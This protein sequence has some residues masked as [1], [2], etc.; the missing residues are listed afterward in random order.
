MGEGG[1]VGSEKFC[2]WSTVM[3]GDLHARIMPVPVKSGVKGDVRRAGERP[4]DTAA[5]A[6]LFRKSLARL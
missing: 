3:L 2:K 1:C 5:L 6:T 4:P